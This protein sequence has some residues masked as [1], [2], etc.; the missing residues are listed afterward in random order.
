LSYSQV[1]SLDGAAKTGRK[2][3]RKR[4]RKTVPN[5]GEVLQMEYHSQI[6]DDLMRSYRSLIAVAKCVEYFPV[7]HPECLREKATGLGVDL[8]SLCDLDTL[9]P[10]EHQPELLLL[11]RDSDSNVDVFGR[12]ICNSADSSTVI[13]ACGKKFLIPSHSSFLLSDISKVHLLCGMYVIN[14]TSKFL[15]NFGVLNL[16][17]FVLGLCDNLTCVMIIVIIYHDYDYLS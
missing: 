17:W 4:A 8:P 16:A 12:V 6:K 2:I 5:K 13:R 1:A 9:V 11:E 7:Q 10:V 15:S 3:R 14:Y